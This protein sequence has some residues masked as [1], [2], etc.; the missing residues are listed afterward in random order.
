[1]YYFSKE[2]AKASKYKGRDKPTKG[3]YNHPISRYY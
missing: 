3:R 1:M 2:V